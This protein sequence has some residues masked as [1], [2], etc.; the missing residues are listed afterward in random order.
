MLRL[1]RQNKNVKVLM[2]IFLQTKAFSESEPC[3]KELSCAND[4][5]IPVIP[6][7][8]EESLP[9]PKQQWSKLTDQDSEVM[10]ANVQ[11]HLSKI[12]GI[13]DRG[14][15]RGVGRLCARCPARS[16]QTGTWQQPASCI[17]NRHARCAYSLT[18]QCVA[19]EALCR[20]ETFGDDHVSVVIRYGYRLTVISIDVIF[21]RLG[22]C[23]RPPLHVLP[24]SGSRSG[25][26]FPHL[27]LRLPRS[28]STGPVVVRF[29]EMANTREREF[30]IPG[31][32]P[33]ALYRNGAVM[34]PS[35]FLDADRLDW[36]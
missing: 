16:F 28:V 10:I 5:K 21:E 3:L 2:L 34:K 7:V 27:C 13:P 36:Q 15:D 17:V 6:I 33:S 8:L 32:E 25:T 23:P 19:R 18:S 14:V 12:N 1:K 24:P 4:K 35:K 9:G 26:H 22:S 20:R 31:A 29:A 30:L 11:E